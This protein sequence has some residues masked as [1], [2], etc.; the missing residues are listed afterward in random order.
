MET[1]KRNGNK[2]S[3]ATLHMPH[4]C[5]G[6][7]SYK[8]T[9]PGTLAEVADDTILPVD[10]FGTFEVNL[11]Q[12]NTMAKPVK[13]VAVKY[14]P[15]RSRNLLPTCKAV[16]Q[17]SKPLIYFK[18]KDCFGIPGEKSLVL[19]LCPLQELFSATGVRL[20]SR[21]GAA[22]TLVAKTAKA[23]KIGTTGQR[24]PAR[25]ACRRKKKHRPCSGSTGPTKLAATV[26]A[27]KTSVQS[28]ANMN[29]S[30][31]GRLRISTYRSWS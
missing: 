29:Q 5:A 19:N 10:G 1:A 7:V 21:Q 17:R 3:G 16:K 22:L 13:M 31:E 24:S 23:M 25:R 30:E 28:R 11:D 15:G 18:N 20:T 27:M 26:L 2:D 14:V 12:P 6:M 4:I 8:I 9:C